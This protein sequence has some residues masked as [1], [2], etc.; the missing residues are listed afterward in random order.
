MK[1][2]RFS[3]LFLLAAVVIFIA[4]G[5]NMYSSVLLMF[6][7]VYMMVDLGVRLWRRW[8]DADR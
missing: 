2:V 1:R 3:E 8:R 6:A 7:A 4:S 5:R